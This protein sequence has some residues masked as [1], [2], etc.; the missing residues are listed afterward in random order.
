MIDIKVKY[1]KRFQVAMILDD[2]KD[3]EISNDENKYDGNRKVNEKI[4]VGEYHARELLS[5]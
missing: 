3:E 5:H 2:Q 1:V 4:D